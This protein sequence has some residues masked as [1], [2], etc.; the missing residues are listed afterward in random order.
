MIERLSRRQGLADG[1]YAAALD[2]LR[3]MVNSKNGHRS[4]EE[5]RALAERDIAAAG[6]ERRDS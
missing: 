5:I 2:R 1:S 6:R 3:E 4:P